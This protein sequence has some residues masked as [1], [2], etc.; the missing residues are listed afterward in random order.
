M[1]KQVYRWLTVLC[2]AV[3]LTGCGKTAGGET[4]FLTESGSQMETEVELTDILSPYNAGE[5]INIKNQTISVKEVNTNLIFQDDN[6]YLI[7]GY[8]HLIEDSINI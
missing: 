2:M 4:E 5:G 6:D 1:K 3:M 8:K 7:L